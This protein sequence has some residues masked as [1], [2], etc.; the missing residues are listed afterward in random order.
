[1]FAYTADGHMIDHQL[2]KTRTLKLA[3]AAFP[4][5]SQKLGEATLL[6]CLETQ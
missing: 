6:K 1:M 5:G 4:P 2:G 3:F